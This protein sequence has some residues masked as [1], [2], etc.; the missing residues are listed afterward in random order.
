MP[1]NNDPTTPGTPRLDTATAKEFQKRFDALVKEIGKVVKGKDP[2]IRLS[3]VC[4]LSGGH[5]LIED[6]PGVAKTTLARCVADVLGGQCRRIQFTPDLLPADITGVMVYDQGTRKSEFQRGP[7]F[8]NVVIADEINRA[9]PKTQSALLEVMEERQVTV[10]GEPQAVPSPFFVVATQNPIDM[11]GTY[12]L[13]EAQLDRFM[14]RV[15]IG[16]PA[17]RTEA[18]IAAADAGPTRGAAQS[19]P[20]EPIEPADFDWLV[21][22][23]RRVR[24]DTA[25]LDYAVGI[26]AA[27]RERPE[28]RLGASPR[29]SIALVRAARVWAA[30]EGRS[31]VIPDDVKRLV[32]PVLQHRLLPTTRH[33]L[34]GKGV[35]V[36]LSSAMASVAAPRDGDGSGHVD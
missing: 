16:Y 6:V 10:A 18:E 23:A 22:T 3:L 2:A 5:L 36:A 27:T 25:V 8:A 21:A 29:G 9:S 14:M 1:E 19:E 28:L 30:S 35:G 31:Y 4:L 32:P 15:G 20:I 26:V 24:C 17:A 34:E 11:E 7:V 33:E 13:P 12:P